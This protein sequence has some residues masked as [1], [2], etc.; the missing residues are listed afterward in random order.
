[1]RIEHPGTT[2]QF[3]CEL[4]ECRFRVGINDSFLKRT[5]ASAINGGKETVSYLCPC[6]GHNCKTQAN[7]T[8]LDGGFT[9]IETPI[10]EEK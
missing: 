10:K 4:C 1:M 5:E 9:R 8:V 7:V 6:C 2:F 3:E